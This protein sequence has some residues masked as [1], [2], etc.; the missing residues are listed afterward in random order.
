M[1]GRGIKRKKGREGVSKEGAVPPLETGGDQLAP[2]A[3]PA[4]PRP[5]HN[6]L[7]EGNSIGMLM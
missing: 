5:V 1:G 7:P 4:A 2:P 6:D 3:P